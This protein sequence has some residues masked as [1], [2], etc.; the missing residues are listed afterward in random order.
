[1]EFVYPKLREFCQKKGYDFQVICQTTIFNNR[2]SQ[3]YIPRSQLVNFCGTVQVMNTQMITLTFCYIAGPECLLTNDIATLIGCGYAMGCAWW[4][5][6]HTHMTT[7]LCLRE[8][9]ACQDI[10][11]GP[12]FVVSDYMYFVVLGQFLFWLNIV[13]NEILILTCFTRHC[14]QRSMVTVH[15][16][17]LLMLRNLSWF[18]VQP[19]MNKQGNFLLSMV[20]PRL[21]LVNSETTLNYIAS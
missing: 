19:L 9:K 8:I 2:Q 1:M 16:C 4:C 3:W 15:F 12:N 6:W 20:Q 13:S 18:L 11:V 5:H 21:V 10:S 7:E 14:F 17:H